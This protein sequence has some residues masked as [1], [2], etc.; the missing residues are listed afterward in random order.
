MSIITKCSFSC[1][2][3]GQNLSLAAVLCSRVR[4]LYCEPWVL[5]S[6]WAC[7]TGGRGV[8]WPS[9]VTSSHL[10]CADIPELWSVFSP[11]RAFCCSLW[12]Q[13]STSVLRTA[14]LGSHIHLVWLWWAQ[15]LWPLPGG[16][17]PS[18]VASS[19]QPPQQC[20]AWDGHPGVLTNGL[21]IDREKLAFQDR[22]ATLIL[23]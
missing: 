8:C 16:F 17:L 15:K 3:G 12:P 20:S 14:V 10:R 5:W 13:L 1:S 7:G 4:L 6:L 19:T 9:P 23:C 18:P 21:A 2:W 22:L 11:E